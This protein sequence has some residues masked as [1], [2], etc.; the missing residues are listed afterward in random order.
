[1]R[2]KVLILIVGTLAFLPASL[3]ADDT[4]FPP[5]PSFTLVGIG[6]LILPIPQRKL[7]WVIEI[8]YDAPVEFQ[9][10]FTLKL[11]KSQ[12]PTEKPIEKHFYSSYGGFE[13]N[14]F[15]LTGDFIPE[16]ILTTGEGHGTG[17]RS[18][19]LEVLAVRGDAFKSLLRVQTS[20]HCGYGCYWRYTHEI[21]IR[22]SSY[23]PKL[24]V[25][26]HRGMP[27]VMCLTLHYEHPYPEPGDSAAV[28]KESVKDFEYDSQTDTMKLVNWEIR[29]QLPPN[30]RV[31][32]IPHGGDA[33]ARAERAAG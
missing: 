16:F 25:A 33:S 6:K 13:L 27:F 14:L 22:S 17:V 32:P 5:Q 24:T 1:M 23:K 9:E 2:F 15:D 30:P 19:N 28:P 4:L 7:Q 12:S 20:A 11:Y 8:A 31:H 29:S 18:E 21:A 26:P 3:K 10:N